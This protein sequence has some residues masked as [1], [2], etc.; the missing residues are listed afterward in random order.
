MAATHDERSKVNHERYERDKPSILAQQKEYRAKKKVRAESIEVAPTNQVELV[1]VVPTQKTL[2]DF[3]CEHDSSKCQIIDGVCTLHRT[4][5][6]KQK[7]DCL[8]NH[9]DVRLTTV[10]SNKSKFNCDVCGHVFTRILYDIKRGSW[11]SMCSSY[12]KYCDNEECDFCHKRSFGSYNGLTKNGKR[13]VDCLRNSEDAKLSMGSSKKCLFDCDVCHHSFE[14]G[15]GHVTN[16]NEESWCG[17][18]SERWKHCQNRTCVFCHE[19]SFAS[20][21]DLTANG[22][23]KVDCLVNPEDGQLTIGSRKKCLFDCDVCGHAFSIALNKIQ[24]QDSWCGMCSNRW[25]KHCQNQECVFCYE[26]SFASYPGLTVNGKRKVDCLRNPEDAKTCKKCLFDCD[27]CGHAFTT[28]IAHVKY[29][30]WCPHC[31]NKT[32]LKVFNFLTKEL[33]LPVKREYIPSFQWRD[34]KKRCRFDFLIVDL[35]II[36]EIDGPQHTEE[37]SQEWIRP[38]LLHPRLLEFFMEEDPKRQIR[39][40]LF[41]RQIVDKW[42]EFMARRDGKRVFRFNQ[43]A[44]WVDSYDWKREMRGK[45]NNM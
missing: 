38:T 4:V 12:W 14:K 43:H 8:V 11:C 18:C 45:I 3:C 36:L 44:I 29:G 40:A 5:N 22:K 21:S 19:R 37:V 9:E 15:F 35:D 27:I 32:E 1:E 30:R 17:M 28:S 16:P 2:H 34:Y 39:T 26:K 25:W 6:G 24:Q 13:K 10:S 7:I 23:R 41:H 42:K 20:Y 31:K 33:N